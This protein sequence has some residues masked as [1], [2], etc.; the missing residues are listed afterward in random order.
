MIVDLKEKTSTNLPNSAFPG[1][2]PQAD[3]VDARCTPSSLQGFLGLWD[4]RNL[5]F[6]FVWRDFESRFKGSLLGA[7]WPLLN[8]LGHLMLYTFLFSIVLQV[9]F[10]TSN[11]TSNFALYLMTAYIPWTAMS[12]A[13][14]SSTTRVLEVPNLVKRV[15]FPLEILPLVLPISSFVNAIIGLSLVAA[16]S[17]FQMGKIQPTVLL[18]PLVLIP[19]FLFTAGLCWFL[20]SIG[21]FIRDCKHFTALALAAGMYI[22]PIVYPADRLPENLRWLLYLNPVSGMITDY[23]KLLLE[24]QLPEITS[25]I[26]YSC[27]SIL[28]CA[29]GFHFF[30]KTKNSFADVV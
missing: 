27:V 17:F 22:T 11:S 21:V 16:F 23:R 26:I 20:A 13:V 5:I 2:T 19:H 14:S 30:F 10:G 18:L 3:L 25:Y 4:I 8:P 29:L 1:L 9:R 15:V 6:K 28:V 12:E 24:G 7:V